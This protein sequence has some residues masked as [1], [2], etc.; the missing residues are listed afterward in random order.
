[1]KEN[2]LELVEEFRR[3]ER[4]RKSLD[5]KLSETDEARY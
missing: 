4:M 5:G 2:L 3:L 1:M